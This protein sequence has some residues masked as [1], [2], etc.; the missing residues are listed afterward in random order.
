[1]QNLAAGLDALILPEMRMGDAIRQQGAS[2]VAAGNKNRTVEMLRTQGRD[3]LADAVER[4]TIDFKQAFSV[5]QSEKASQ[6]AFNRSKQLASFT[7]GLK[8]SSVPKG[9][10]FKDAQA[11][12]K[13][14]TNLPRIKGFAGVTEAYS[15]IVA[16]AQDPSAA[17]DLSLIFNF[18]KV[19]DP[20]STVREGE[21][22]TA[23]N[24]GGVDSKVRSLFNSVVDGTRLDVSQRAD[25]L[26]RANRLYKSQE[27]LVLPL[28]DYYENIA[29]SRGFDPA[30]VL[31]QFGY[32][33]E[34][35]GVSPEFA[36][37]PPPPMPEGATANG[38]PL[39][40]EAWL[41]IWK[42]RTVDEKKKFMETGSFE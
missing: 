23:Q 26:D 14:F 15:R 11:F 34:M 1:M 16:S 25:F 12:R 6:T 37:M 22:A 9:G 42:S 13:E 30:R 31:P 19:L 18:M 7:A 28:Y 10:E 2:N 4:G 21:F 41:T 40:Q 20:G 39:T 3:D 29:S 17:G 8:A 35:P 38:L 27:D 5:M 32:T 36:P 24:A 33:G